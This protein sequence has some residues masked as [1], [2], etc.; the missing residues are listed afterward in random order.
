MH[1]FLPF[2]LI[3]LE[4]IIFPSIEFSFSG[5]Y[6]QISTNEFVSPFLIISL[7]NLPPDIIPNESII[8]VFPAPVSPVNTFNPLF[9]SM[10]KSSIIPIFFMCNV[11]IIIR[12]PKKINKIFVRSDYIFFILFCQ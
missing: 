11:V 1:I 12:P 6:I 5:S 4:T 2:E 10:L 9:K 8:N 3:S 7:E